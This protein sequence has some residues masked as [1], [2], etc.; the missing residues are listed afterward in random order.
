MINGENW[1]WLPIQRGRFGPNSVRRFQP[2]KDRVLDLF[3][4]DPIYSAA[5]V[6]C[7]NHPRW[8]LYHSFESISVGLAGSHNQSGSR[9]EILSAAGKSQT[10]VEVGFDG[11]D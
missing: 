3:V 9:L 2:L 4:G 10:F 8:R 5:G 7:H 11:D 1:N 6:R